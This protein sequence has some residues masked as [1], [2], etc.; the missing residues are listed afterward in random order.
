[1]GDGG[2]LHA[3]EGTSSFSRRDVRFRHRASDIRIEGVVFLRPERCFRVVTMQQDKCPSGRDGV[4]PDLAAR[5]CHYR[6]R[7]TRDVGTWLFELAAARPE[8]QDGAS[9]GCR[10]CGKQRGTSELQHLLWMPSNVGNLRHSY[11]E[12]DCKRKMHAAGRA[13]SVV[14]QGFSG[15]PTYAARRRAFLWPKAHLLRNGAG[16]K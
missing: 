1:M 8:W 5:P 4:L 6:A 10:S 9:V 11:C 16:D 15:P 12:T 14:L 7:Y 2:Q 3:E 13:S